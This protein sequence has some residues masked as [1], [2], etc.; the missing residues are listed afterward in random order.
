MKYHNCNNPF[1]PDCA[2]PEP[3]VGKPSPVPVPMPQ[4]APVANYCRPDKLTLRTKVIPANLGD[5]TGEFAPSVGAEY[6]CIVLYQSNGAVYIYDSNGVFTKV[7][8]ADLAETIEQILAELSALDVDVDELYNPTKPY[9]TVL[10]YADLETVDPATVPANGFMEVLNDETHN[11]DT[12][13]Y[14]YNTGA[15]AWRA[16]QQA[17]P[18]LTRAQVHALVEALQANINNVMNKEM[19]DVTNLQTNI[20]AEVNRAEAAEQALTA[21]TEQ[22]S[23][24]IEDIVNSPDVRYIVDTYADLE[25]IAQSTI[26]DQDYA[27]VLQDE[28]HEDASTYYQFNKTEQKWT[29]VGQTG[30]YYTKEQIDTKLDAI[31]EE[32]G[33]ISTELTNLNTGEGV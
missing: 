10:T 18:Y 30:P 32:L 33:D 13:L 17:T 6:N 9:Q 11:G 21:T 22:L 1:L 28:T 25:A 31:N 24:R 23:Q 16:E 12:W 8:D 29:Y 14:V 20:N 5:D 26:G 7:K 15:G 3:P 19:E 2:H 27:R 4:S